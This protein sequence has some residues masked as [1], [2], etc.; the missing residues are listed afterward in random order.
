MELFQK[1]AERFGTEV[2]L[3][4]ATPRR[5]LASARSGSRPRRAPSRADAVIL[6]TGASAQL[7]RAR[8]REAAP[9]Q[10]RL[11]LRHLRRRA[12]PR[13]ADGGG[14]RRRHGDGGGALPDRFATEVTVVHRRDR[15][16]ASKIMQERALANPKIRFAWNTAVEEVLGG[17]VRDRRAD[18]RPEE[19][20]HERAPR[21]GRLRRD[22][23]PAEHA[24][25]SAG[26]SSSI[27]VGY[28]KVEPGTTRTSVEGVFACGDVDGSDLPPG[29]SRPR[30]PAA[31]RRS[32]PSAGS[33]RAAA[34]ICEAACTASREVLRSLGCL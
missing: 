24:S 28:I 3:E 34:W 6:A 5:S 20:R 23:P 17:D 4:D 21:R 25:S 27:D 11:G 15:L 10:G 9:E 29:R 1:Q 31:W 2:L 26:S 16:R 32:T 8:L 30:A 12:L 33:Q 13:Q 19:R 22:R 14:R 18:A 7:A